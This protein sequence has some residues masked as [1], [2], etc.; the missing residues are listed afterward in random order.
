MKTH[1]LSVTHLVVGL[2]FLG[3][4]SSWALRQADV[5]GSADVTWLIPV[6]LIIAGGVG[7]VAA[8][9]KGVR[10]GRNVETVAA[11]P[12]TTYDAPLPQDYTSDLDRRLDEAG[13]T[14][15]TSTATDNTDDQT[16]DTTTDTAVTDPHEG[17]SR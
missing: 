3:V 7:L 5:I 2:V 8:M 13:S 16:T 4:A 1:P 12:V 11:A 15:A 6:S 10:G 9:A 14:S 17:E